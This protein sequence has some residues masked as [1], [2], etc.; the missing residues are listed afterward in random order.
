MEYLKFR[1]WFG[2]WHSYKIHGKP[3]DSPPWIQHR[4]NLL[5]D[6]AYT[7][8][9]VAQRGILH[10]LQCLAMDTGNQ[11]PADAKWI[12]WKLRTKETIEFKV[13]ETFLEVSEHLPNVFVIGEEIRGDK[14]RE[15]KRKGDEIRKETQPKAK[16][17]GPTSA[18]AE[19]ND[20]LR[21]V[22]AKEGFEAIRQQFQKTP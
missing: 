22:E 4:R 16:G 13:F 15:D 18:R 21:R 11:I 14:I 20:A 6:H 2:H 8:L 1:K 7:S 10:G 9:T 17:L 19:V 3:S 12:Q 5:S